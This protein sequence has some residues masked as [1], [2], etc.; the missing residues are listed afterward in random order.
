MPE[1]EAIKRIKKYLKRHMEARG[2]KILNTDKE[3]CN[4]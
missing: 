4:Q 1:K 2:M 3:N